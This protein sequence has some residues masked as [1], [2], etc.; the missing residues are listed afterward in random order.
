M[1]TRS[2]ARRPSL[3]LSNG[4]GERDT[5]ARRT[6][7]L[8]PV[9]PSE[10][11][12]MRCSLDRYGGIRSRACDGC[13][14]QSVLSALMDTMWRTIAMRART[15]SPLPARRTNASKSESRSTNR[16]SAR[17]LS[18]W[19]GTRHHPA[20]GLTGQR[21]GKGQR[22]RADLGDQHD[23]RTPLLCQRPRQHIGR[24]DDRQEL[25]NL[26]VELNERARRWI[27]RAPRSLSC[28]SPV[29]LGIPSP[30]R[31]VGLAKGPPRTR[32]PH[33]WRSGDRGAA[34]LSGL[35]VAPY[36]LEGRLRPYA[37]RISRPWAVT[38]HITRMSMTITVSAQSG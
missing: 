31:G 25:P 26:S 36:R 13:S 23:R 17:P 32:P 19:R 4:D 6:V 29:R 27:A 9:G 14:C 12:G 33:P 8:G 1:F 15:Y 16:S 24:D 21:G 34:E 11:A 5:R 7:S 10:D 38:A 2:A 20:E 3:P 30:S 35:E 22:S 18:P 37:A 28:P